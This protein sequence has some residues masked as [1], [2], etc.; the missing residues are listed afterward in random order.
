MIK[1]FQNSS[2]A[3]KEG[4]IIKGDKYRFTVLTSRL[5]RIEYNNDGLFE[6]RATLTVIN[7]EFEVPEFNVTDKSEL[8]TIT[9]KD[10]E[11]TYTKKNSLPTVF[12][13]NT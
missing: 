3:A 2:P 7:R 1:Y 13:L 11:L 6:D 10:I 9:T 5:I 4:A 12:K 8:L